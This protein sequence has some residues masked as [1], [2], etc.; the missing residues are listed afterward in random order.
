METSSDSC[1]LKTFHSVCSESWY[2]AQYRYDSMQSSLPYKPQNF[3]RQKYDQ[4]GQNC[5]C[6]S[7]GGVT[8]FCGWRTLS[9]NRRKW[10]HRQQ[11]P[12]RGSGGGHS[13]PGFQGQLFDLVKDSWFT[14]LRGRT[15]LKLEIHQRGHRYTPSKPP[16]AICKL[17]LGVPVGPF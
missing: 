11:R 4:A 14:V 3:N 12:L 5:R 15:A 8:T 10:P 7:A 13:P 16:R 17:P 1:R 6:R 9:A 2:L